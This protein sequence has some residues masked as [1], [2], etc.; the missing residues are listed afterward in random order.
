MTLAR[1]TIASP[2]DNV[3]CAVEFDKA[4]RWAVIS[5][6]A[7]VADGVPERCDGQEDT[8]RM[9][10]PAIDILWGSISTIPRT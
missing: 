5:S 8:S 9:L 10:E 1:M 3:R 6:R 7:L 4:R 2:G